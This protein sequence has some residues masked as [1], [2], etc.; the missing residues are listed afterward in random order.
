MS[1]ISVLAREAAR[2]TD[3]TSGSSHWTGEAAAMARSPGRM[4][5][6]MPSRPAHGADNCSF[7]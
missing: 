2:I 4:F 5:W 3:C 6:E 7:A 1:D